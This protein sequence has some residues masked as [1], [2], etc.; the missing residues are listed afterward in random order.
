MKFGCMGDSVNLASRLNGL[1]K[2]YGVEVVCSRATYSALPADSSLLCRQL[3]LVK[4][5]GRREPTPI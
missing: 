2:Y 1:C 3:D 4:V 5:K